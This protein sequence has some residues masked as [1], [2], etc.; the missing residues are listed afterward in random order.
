MPSLAAADIAPP[1]K[2]GDTVRVI[3]LQLDATA[4]RYRV[5]RFLDG[6]LPGDELELRPGSQQIEGSRA[7]DLQLLTL[8]RRPLTV[9]RAERYPT[10]DPDDCTPFVSLGEGF[11]YRHGDSCPDAATF[12][13]D[14]KAPLDEATSIAL[15]RW[16]RQMVAFPHLTQIE[17]AGDE[18]NVTQAVRWLVDHGIPREHLRPLIVPDAAPGAD[19]RPLAWD[20]KPIPIR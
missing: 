5:V 16:A 17:I 1:V 11:I 15:A 12:P 6:R 20:G 19:L 7:G 9:V 14:E 18:R 8:A 10:P 3:A 4:R 13:T 2:R